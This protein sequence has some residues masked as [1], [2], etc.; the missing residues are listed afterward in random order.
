MNPYKEQPLAVSV[1]YNEY[2]IDK[3]MKMVEGDLKKTGHKLSDSLFIS[4][5]SNLIDSLSAPNN[6][7]K[8][9]FNHILE[10]S[11]LDINKPIKLLDFFRGFFSV[12]ETMLDN[13]KGKNNE[14]SV[15]I[16]KKRAL[17]TKVRECQKEEVIHENGLGSQS[18]LKILVKLP[19]EKK[20]NCPP[21][22]FSFFFPSEPRK[23][24]EINT[25]DSIDVIHKLS[26]PLDN[27]KIINDGVD[28]IVNGSEKIESLSIP[29]L[30]DEPKK[31]QYQDFTIKILWI[32][33]KI[34]FMQK[35]I[36]DIDR[37]IQENTESISVMNTSIKQLENCFRGYFDSQRNNNGN[38]PQLN[39]ELI[40]SDNIEKVVL[41]VMGRDILIWD[42]IV[43][44]LNRVILPLSLAQFFRKTDFLTLLLSF[45]LFGLEYDII[46]RKVLFNTLF[47]LFGTIGVDAFWFL[48]YYSNWSETMDLD[49]PIMGNGIRKLIVLLTLLSIVLKLIMSFALWR[50]CLEYKMYKINN[51]KC[52]ANNKEV[53]RKS[54]KKKNDESPSSLNNSLIENLNEDFINF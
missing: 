47:L 45:I 35:Q 24:F 32:N 4:P 25:G 52:D 11:N 29:N 26:I 30:Q 9:L 12:Y 18:S 20:N 46:K 8:T 14:N 53:F 49:G 17:Q 3:Y 7:N 19:Y 36:N 23:Q 27:M 33:S 13:V 43:F 38:A 48:Y 50:M 15:L 31:V 28:I 6:F 44:A 54:D 51:I 34:S 10:F 2:G 5:L 40:I 39:T 1:N 37:L 16:S 42:T 22:V 41:K 21:T